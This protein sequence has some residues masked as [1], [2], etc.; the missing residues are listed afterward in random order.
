MALELQEWPQAS[1]ECSL[2]GGKATAASKWK[3]Q[4]FDS[5][6]ELKLPVRGCTFLTATRLSE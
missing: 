6:V 5:S 1:T 2:P 4:P 3:F